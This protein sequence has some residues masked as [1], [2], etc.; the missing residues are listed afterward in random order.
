MRRAPRLLAAA[1]GLLVAGFL[2]STT[3]AFSAVTENPANTFQ[4]APSFCGVRTLAAAGDAWVVT[5]PSGANHGGDAELYVVSRAQDRRTF[6]AFD[7]PPVPAGCALTDA[8]LR[9][10]ATSSTGARTI[11]AYRVSSG[12][13][14]GGV[15]WAIQPGTSGPP[16]SSPSGTGWREW[17][18]LQ[19]VLEMYASGNHGFMLRDQVEGSGGGGFTQV[20]D[21]RE[22]GPDGPALVLTFG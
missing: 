17:P 6:V 12:W 4:A 2:G 15:T 21:S 3:A 9:L 18:V 11:L 19:Q 20:Y 16:A 13:T 1:V 22:S 8:R 10:R 14:E 5:N 7:L